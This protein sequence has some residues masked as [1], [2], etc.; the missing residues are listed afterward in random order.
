MGLIGPAELRM[1]KETA[2]LINVC[3]G[4]II[5]QRALVRALKEGWIAGAA[6]DV[7]EEEPLPPDSELWQMK[8]VIITPHVSSW[9][10]DYRRRA[11]Q[12]FCRN[13]VHIVD[14]AREY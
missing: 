5:Q 2:Y 14:R 9:S 7:F 4:T 6:L 1:M 3:R 13:L 8:N 11:C 10:S 12:V